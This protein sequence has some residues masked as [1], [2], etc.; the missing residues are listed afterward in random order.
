MCN[1][2][3]TVLPYDA[4]NSPTQYRVICQDGVNRIKLGDDYALALV[5]IGRTPPA[6]VSFDFHER[7]VD[8]YSSNPVFR[9]TGDVIDCGFIADDF[10]G[11]TWFR[12]VNIALRTKP[13][14][15]RPLKWVH[16]CHRTSN[17]DSIGLYVPPF[18]GH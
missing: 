4:T 12:M 13:G 3:H 6:Q 2:L 5:W 7:V 9:I 18:Y 16:I 10:L 1:N 8:T 14:H 11:A 17:A 15:V